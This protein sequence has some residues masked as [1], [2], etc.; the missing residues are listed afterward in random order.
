[1]ACASC[2]TVLHPVGGLRLRSARTTPL[3]CPVIGDGGIRF[4]IP[5]YAEFEV[6]AEMRRFLRRVE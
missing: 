2:S 4:A 6:V 3:G 1:M 5:P